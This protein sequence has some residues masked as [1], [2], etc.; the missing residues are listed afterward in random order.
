MLLVLVVLV[1]AVAVGWLVFQVSGTKRLAMEK[2]Y[3]DA[4]TGYLEVGRSTVLGEI[5]RLRAEFDGIILETAPLQRWAAIRAWNLPDG[6]VR[7]FDSAADNASGG[8]SEPVLKK[9]LDITVL[10]KSGDTA[11]A[12]DQ[13]DILLGQPGVEA[14]R[15]ADGRMLAPMLAYLAADLNKD[16]PMADEYRARFR[17]MVLDDE[18]QS[19]MPPGQAQFSLGRIREWDDGFE[20]VSALRF[21]ETTL[22]WTDTE[23][24]AARDSGIPQWS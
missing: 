20:V 13:I 2:I 5:G 21:A 10:Q 18:V 16:G 22:E 14:E 3:E 23:A 8:L 6:Y 9:L 4:R 1:P 12:A 17:S 15:M 24:R 11:G 7:S 19:A